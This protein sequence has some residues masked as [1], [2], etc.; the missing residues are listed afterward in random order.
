MAKPIVGWGPNKR[1]LLSRHGIRCKG[2]LWCK[3][4]LCQWDSGYMFEREIR[5]GR[6]SKVLQIVHTCTL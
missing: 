3:W 4:P 2:A 6:L 5:S 1:G